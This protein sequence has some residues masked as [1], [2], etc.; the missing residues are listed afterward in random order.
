MRRR[1]ITGAVVL[2]FVFLTAGACPKSSND[3]IPIRGGR[4]TE[5]GASSTDV[6]TQESLTCSSVPYGPRSQHKH[7][8]IWVHNGD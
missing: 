2:G 3:P 6:H 5:E 4:C 8:L 7:H 1:L